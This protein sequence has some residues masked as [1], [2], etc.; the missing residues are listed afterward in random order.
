MRFS[1]MAY[2]LPTET[3]S[4]KALGQIR[5]RETSGLPR[6]EILAYNGTGGALV[7]NACYVLSYDGDEETNPKII[8]AAAVASV[9]RLLCVA[10]A[11]TADT[12]IDWVVIE[13][14]YSVRCDGTTNI[15]KD[16]FLKL[17][18]GTDA[19]ALIKDGTSLTE[20]SVAIAREAFETDANGNAACYIL[21]R[22]AVI[23]T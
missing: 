19:D 16:D 6:W 8:T 10:T 1:G 15:A 11:A 20:A 5:M 14:Y 12:A 13:G 22:E 18:P 9:R 4:E 3:T 2:S 21:G 23:N 7:A 17:A